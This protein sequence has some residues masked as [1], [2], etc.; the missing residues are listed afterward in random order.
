MN[1]EPTRDER[2]EA[3]PAGGSAR[4]LR[5]GLVTLDQARVIERELGPGEPDPAALQG[6]VADGVITASQA[7][8]VGRVELDGKRGGLTTGEGAQRSAATALQRGGPRRP[9][10]PPLPLDAGK[11]G[12][13]LAAFAFAGL[14]WALAGL[15]SDLVA[16]PP[17]PLGAE[18]VDGVRVLASVLALIG[19]RR[20]YRGA[21]HGKPLVMTG[22]PL[23]ALV[24]LAAGSRRLADP[25]VVALLASCGVLCVLTLLSRFAPPR[26]ADPGVDAGGDRAPRSGRVSLRRVRAVAENAVEASS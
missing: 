11:L 19:G 25:W 26:P 22:L 4:W 21:Q 6:L 3:P 20:V 1:L 7:A 14:L 2:L 18:L 17:K 13:A 5:A 8:A 12:V 9:S 23:Y 24:T 15:A 16:T 10:S